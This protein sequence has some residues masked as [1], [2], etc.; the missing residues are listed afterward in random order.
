MADRP[1][2]VS[3]GFQGGQVL[4]TRVASDELDSLRK[5]LGNGG[6]HTLVAEDGEV[7]LDLAQVVYVLTDTDEHRVGF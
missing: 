5:A 2:K 4:D 7:R 6:W 3:V 1:R